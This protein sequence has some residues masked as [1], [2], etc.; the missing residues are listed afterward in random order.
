LRDTKRIRRFAPRSLSN[1][2]VLR[3]IFVVAH[4]RRGVMGRDGMLPWTLPEDL[5]HFK[6]L[7]IDKPVVMGRK[8]FESIGRPLVRRRN[9]VLTRDPSFNADGVEVAHSVEEAI[10]IAGD[11][12]EIAVIG[13]AQIFNAFAPLVNTSYVTRVEANVEGN[14]HYVPPNRAHTSEVLGTHPADERNAYDM[15]FLRFDYT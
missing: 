3:I 4:D 7:T 13:G 11:V 10:R 15:T 6:R 8:T 12:P 9:I 2:A 5:K 14:V 1:V